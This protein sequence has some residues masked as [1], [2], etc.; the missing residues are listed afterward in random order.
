MQFLILCFKKF[1]SNFAKFIVKIWRNLRKIL[2]STKLKILQN[3]PNCE[4][5][6]FAATLC[7]TGVRGGAS[8]YSLGTPSALTQIVHYSSSYYTVFHSVNYNSVIQSH[9]PSSLCQKCLEYSYKNRACH[10]WS[11]LRF[12]LAQ[13]GTVWHFRQG[14]ARKLKGMTE[15]RD[16]AY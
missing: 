2:W 14:G 1:S 15:I 13:C 11:W 12:F 4:N 10:G 8:Q 3:L 9:V 7:R 16:I 5:E 6:N